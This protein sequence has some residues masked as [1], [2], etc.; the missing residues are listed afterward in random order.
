MAD[1]DGMV[2]MPMAPLRR[3]GAAVAATRRDLRMLHRAPPLDDDSADYVLTC[4][5]EGIP[6]TRVGAMPGLPPYAVI[7]SWRRQYPEFDAACVQASEAGAE[8]MLWQTIEIADDTER[9]PACRE[10]SI[11]ARQH[12]MKVLHR[13]RFDPATRVAELQAERMADELTDDVLAQMVIEGQARRVE[14]GEAPRDW[15]D[16]QERLA[17]KR[18][19]RA[20]IAEAREA[21]RLAEPR[22]TQ[23]EYF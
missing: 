14:A 15:L 23:D 13:K 22:T 19:T 18:E 8:K 10:V 7:N 5:A 16:V 17:R 3:T 12:A 21:F 9:H 1:D 6:I 11:R 4:L 20:A 2:E